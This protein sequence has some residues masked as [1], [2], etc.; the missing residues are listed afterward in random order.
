MDR[1]QQKEK[2]SCERATFLTEEGK[3]D[4]EKKDSV[5]KMKEKIG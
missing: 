5:Q 4:G 1:M 2:S 3:E